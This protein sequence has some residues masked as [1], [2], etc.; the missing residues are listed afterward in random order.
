MSVTFGTDQPPGH[1]ERQEHIVR[2]RSNRLRELH[3]P[4]VVDMREIRAE[5]VSCNCLTRT[6]IPRTQSPLHE[7]DNTP[8][9]AV[10]VNAG[11]RP[12]KACHWMPDSRLS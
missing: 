5:P 6:G 12:N 8:Q 2:I 9:W 11:L 1:H 7:P 4:G 10:F 3:V